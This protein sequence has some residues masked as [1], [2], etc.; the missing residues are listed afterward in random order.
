MHISWSWRQARWR[1]DLDFECSLAWS[2][3]QCFA[4]DQMCRSWYLSSD[5]CWCHT[6]RHESAFFAFG[7]WPPASK[8][9]ATSC[10]VSRTKETHINYISEGNSVPI[11]PLL[12]ADVVCE[13]ARRMSDPF[14]HTHCRANMTCW[15]VAL[16]GS[17]T[18]LGLMI[19]IFATVMTSC[20]INESQQF[21]VTQ[22]SRR[23]KGLQL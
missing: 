5:P 14:S 3:A 21:V 20:D 7:S 8:G 10:R 2:S 1:R 13:P 22:D 4:E 9:A 19:G 23:L 6:S 17:S 16:E 11:I 18:E 15:V 12:L